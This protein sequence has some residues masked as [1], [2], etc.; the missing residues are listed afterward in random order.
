[1]S[2]SKIKVL[3]LNRFSNCWLTVTLQKS[4]TWSIMIMAAVVLFVQDAPLYEQKVG[5]LFHK[6]D[7][8]TTLSSGL[9]LSQFWFESKLTKPKKNASCLMLSRWRE[10]KSFRKPNL[11]SLL[12]SLISNLFNKIKPFFW[13]EINPRLASSGECET[14]HV[15]ILCVDSH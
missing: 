1:M 15:T 9:I 6:K 11:G 7:F 14:T 3:H 8:F 4:M 2:I 13:L 12:V 5:L 10:P